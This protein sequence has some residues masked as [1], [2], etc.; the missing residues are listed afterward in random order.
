M[1][2]NALLFFSVLT[3]LLL[4]TPS[5]ALANDRQDHL[6]SM[7]Q[8]E[9]AYQNLDVAP[10]EWKDEIL[11]ARN[12]IIYST[13]WTVDG[14]VA[15]ELPDGTIEELPEFSDLFPDWDVP[16]L[17]EDVRKQQLANLKAYDFQILAANYVGFVYL[18]EPSDSSATLPFYT[19]YS[20]AKRVTMTADSLPGT[21]YNGG[22]TNI[23]TG[24][25]LGYVNN[26]RQGGKIYLTNP[27]R[28]TAYGARASTYSTTGYAQ[29]SVVDG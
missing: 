27:V 4:L 2:K 1:K 15:Y 17:K 26:V 7:S 3:L 5:L 6:A 18:F 11:E 12:S 23:D 13:S 8:E 9:L 21:S 28:N 19:F 14:Q 24:A 22:F 29:M 10:E 20:S 16:R 25:D